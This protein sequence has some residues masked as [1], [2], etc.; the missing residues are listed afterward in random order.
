MGN[1]FLFVFVCVCDTFQCMYAHEEDSA[2]VCL[3]SSLTFHFIFIKKCLLINQKPVVLLSLNVQCTVGILLYKMPSNK[4]I[5]LQSMSVLSPF[6]CF[7]LVKYPYGL[8]VGELLSH[9]YTM[10]CYLCVNTPHINLWT[11]CKNN[12]HRPTIV[13]ANKMF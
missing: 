3:L 8:Q 7:V 5:G 1:H 4:F 9:K 12:V 6:F 13:P 2:A 10:L 11:E